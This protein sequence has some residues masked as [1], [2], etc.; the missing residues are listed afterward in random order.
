MIVNY[1]ISDGLKIAGQTA[2]A[3]RIKADCLRLI[4]KSGFAEYYG[5]INAES[6]GGDAFTWTAAMVIEIL[7]THEIA[8]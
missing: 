3:D 1:M 6:C 5:P 4:E 2:I 7:N 8:A